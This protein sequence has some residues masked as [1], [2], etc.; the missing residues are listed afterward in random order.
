MPGWDTT[1]HIWNPPHRC[2]R[3]TATR[4]WG[5][6]GSHRPGKLP[7]IGRR[8]HICLYPNISSFP[9]SG[10]P[11]GKQWCIHDL[12][13]PDR[14]LWSE[15]LASPLPPLFVIVW[16]CFRQNESRNKFPCKSDIR[17]IVSALFLSL[18]LPFGAKPPS[19]N[20]PINFLDAIGILTYMI[21]SRSVNRKG[22]P[23][24]NIAF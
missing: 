7:R 24:W 16:S 6:R 15:F 2:R 19:S 1:A 10:H 4:W 23:K 14:L 12:Y 20:W 3:S 22:D 18:L 8:R 5:P 21:F 13:M 17:Y 9:I 11:G